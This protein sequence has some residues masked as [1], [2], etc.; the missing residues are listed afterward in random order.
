MKACFTILMLCLAAV[1]YGQKGNEGGGTDGGGGTK[2]AECSVNAGPDQ[3]ICFNEPMILNAPVSLD[4][5]VPLDLAW[6]ST[7]PALS[8]TNQYGYT[9]SVLGPM[10]GS[11]WSPGPYVFKFCA[12]CKD[13]NNDGIND[14]VCDEVV[15]TVTPD[16]TQPVITEPDGT[17]DGQFTVCSEADITVTQPAN[18]ELSNVSIVP[19]DGLVTVT[20]TGGVVHLDRLD[21]GNS[22][23][24][25]CS[26]KVTYS[27]F[28]DGCQKDATVNVTFV[29][30]QDPNGDGIIEAQIIEC[31]SCDDRLSLRGDR[32]GCGATGTWTVI[33]SPAG[34]G[35]TFS[36]VRPQDGDANIRVTMPGVYTFLY[37]VTGPT[38]CANSV[39]EISCEVL[40]VDSFTLGS[41][42]YW[43]FCNDTLPKG[44]YTY[45]FINIPNSVY[46]WAVLGASP[47]EVTIVHN[48][49]SSVT[50]TVHQDIPLSGR[51]IRIRLTSTKYYVDVDCDGPIP[52]FEIPLP[53][54][55]PAE[56]LP[57][58][59]AYQDSIRLA[60][61]IFYQDTFH[62]PDTICF[63]TC[64]TV[65]TI[66]IKG[67]IKVVAHD[68]QFL[69]SNGTEYVT[70]GDYYNVTHNGPYSTIIN[71][72]SQPAGGGLTGPYYGFELL[73]LNVQ[74]CGEYVFEIRASPA[75]LNTCVA[76]D[77]FRII[78]ETPKPVTAGTDQVKCCNE[79]I[80]LNANNPYN[81]GAIGTWSLVNCSNGCSVTFVDPHDP[82]TQMFVNDSCVN[83]PVT[84]YLQWSF[85]SEDNSC[86]PADTTRVTVNDCIVPCNN[87]DVNVTSDCNDSTVTLTVYDQNGNLINPFA[88]SVNWTVG[89]TIYPGNPVTVP[90]NGV[91]LNYFV[92]V[93]LYSGTS[94]RCQDT[95]SGVTDCPTNPSGCGITIL[96]S[97]DECGNVVLTAVDSNGN[98]V[99]YAF[100]KDHFRWVVYSG[101]DDLGSGFVH[102]NVNPITVHPGACYS[103][104]YEHY[105]Y[106]S[107]G[108]TNPGTWIDYCRWELPKTCVTTVC[109]G[110]CRDFPDFFIAG[111][112][113]I[114]DLSLGLTFPAGCQSVCGTYTSSG[115]LGVFHTSTNLP[116]DPTQYNILWENGGT[117]TYVNG[118]ISSINTV[119]IT[120]K[121]DTCCFWEDGYKT[122]CCGPVPQSILCEQPIVKYCYDDGTY[123]YIPGPP[124]ISWIGVAG[125]N[126]YELEITVG[127]GGG[128]ESCC[129]GPGLVQ[130][131]TVT[132]SPWVFPSTWN[133]F[134]I[135]VRALYPEGTCE[136]SEWSNAYTYCSRETV[137]S[138]VITVCGCCHGE[139]SA[140]GLSI[141]TRI[142]EE[143]ELLAYMKAHPGTGYTNLRDAL[144]ATGFESM[145]EPRFRVFPNPASET[146]T[147]RPATDV[148]EAF[149]VEVRDMLQRSWQKQQYEAAQESS[150]NIS[151]LPKGIY[152][153][154][155]RNAGGEL[156]QTE[157][158]TVIR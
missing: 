9:T 61:T 31:P 84:V 149:E 13:L 23:Q 108:P 62:I 102:N 143:E 24:G 64:E 18:G 49:T 136:T 154:T 87:L 65:A 127:G 15:V 51:N 150:L 74:D 152:M 141:P 19:N 78:I 6:S 14:E 77:T 139:R 32:P 57:F 20:I 105:T 111:C 98:V 114:L 46:N 45:S 39:F 58:V 138:P 126:A 10:G 21:T 30:P 75:T 34:S 132:A 35:F 155:I 50:I 69:C 53:S 44:V 12:V 33:G 4:Y 67:G 56:V 38:T 123:T 122:I 144:T 11:N 148:K 97:C 121:K 119:R 135:R 157:K 28:N 95:H 120:S 89:S 59:N 145:L 99:P 36:N 92:N 43:V 1:L 104:L 40:E 3:T 60:D 133:C 117:G 90:Y 26:Y 146:L 70:L 101:P 22:N 85:A 82:N 116:V 72:L 73:A 54:S 103:L 153:L 71:V 17:Q 140:E 130:Y 52:V 8:F 137:C 25:A 129:P 29:Q 109:P 124:Q 110:P 80:R 107:S 86:N 134:T 112:G 147:I 118:L 47:S 63:Y 151:D 113:D 131:M 142:V 100:F 91:P 37:T 128:D 2:T 27:I 96:E 115:M 88:Y 55:D 42:V 68:A 125:A 5:N 106:A 156:L 66:F 93:I 7:N 76:I 79:P 158:I 83:M 81:C 16:V 48:N 94:I 41:D